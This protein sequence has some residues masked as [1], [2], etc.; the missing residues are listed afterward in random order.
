MTEKEIKQEAKNIFNNLTVAQKEH[1]YRIYADEQYSKRKE[2]LKDI[3]DK[4]SNE[5]FTI[6]QFLTAGY[7]TDVHSVFEEMLFDYLYKRYQKHDKIIDD[8]FCD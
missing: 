4:L 3:A 8:M 5:R 1:I 6:V 2:E 7:S